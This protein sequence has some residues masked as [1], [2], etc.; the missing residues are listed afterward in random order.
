M[1]GSL[2]EAKWLGR[3][4]GGFCTKSMEDQHND[5][6]SLSRRLLLCI[7]QGRISE[8]RP[9][10]SNHNPSIKTVRLHWRVSIINMNGHVRT[11]SKTITNSVQASAHKISE[12]G[13]EAITKSTKAVQ[14][15]LHYDQLP[16]WRK[17]DSYIR[18]GYR[19]ELNSFT[20][21]F[22][23]L[24]YKHNELVNT[25][26][27][28]LPA[29]GYLVLL[30]GLDFWSLHS[31]IKVSRTDNVFFQFYIAATAGCLSLSAVYHGT[32]T[33]SEI[34]SRNFL[35]L[36][37]L[38]IVLGIVGTN[39]SSTYFGLYGNLSLQRLYFVL[40]V[41]C[42]VFATRNLLRDDIDGPGA[43]PR[44]YILFRPQC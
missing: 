15:I 14:H 21:C 12:A 19:R 17:V 7:K 8:S 36:D 35:K 32:N 11:L 5:A 38:G 34:I 27:H 42:S 18:Y 30:L 6:L 31:D 1:E 16:E 33:H 4:N 37:Y 43:A 44:R 20:D 23:S 41:V 26:S 13:Q 28:L 29:L 3:Q 10:T 24:F 25:W 39:V 2:E 40:I 9:L 22:W